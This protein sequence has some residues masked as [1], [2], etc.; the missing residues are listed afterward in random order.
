LGKTLSAVGK[1]LVMKKSFGSITAIAVASAAFALTATPAQAS[2]PA[3]TCDAVT[4]QVIGSQLKIGSVD[5]STSPG[6]LTY[7]DVG[8]PYSES[9]NGGGY[10]VVD[11]YLHAMSSVASNEL[12]RIASDGSVESLGVPAG[13]P[14]HGFLAGDVTPDGQHLVVVDIVDKSVWSID[15]TAVSAVN[16]GS[17]PSSPSQI[18]LG[19]F[20]IVDSG[21]TVTAYGLDVATGAL[22]SFDPTA[23]PI[24][25]NV[26]SSVAIGA[27]SAKGAVWTDSSGNLTTFVNTSG[28][29]Y[30]ITDPSSS[31]P[32][33]TLVANGT[34][35]GGNDGMKCALSA[36]AFEPATAASDSSLPSTGV[37]AAGVVSLAVTLLLAGIAGL[38]GLTARRRSR[39]A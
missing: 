38:A 10:N 33:V 31:S 28:E 12:L 17:L 21:S 30:A 26:N 27:T 35:V 25:V 32:A 34:A 2:G 3:F 4:Y 22:V 19:D 11:N 39:R 9:Y 13:L 14:S 18:D 29:V 8:A 15:L 5:L 20:A 6:T 23:N 1:A 37:D 7:T 16:I 36:S 24:V